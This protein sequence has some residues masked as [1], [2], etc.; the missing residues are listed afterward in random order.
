MAIHAYSERQ[1]A[2]QKETDLDDKVKTVSQD[3]GDGYQLAGNGY[4]LDQPGVFQNRAG[5]AAP[6]LGK[7][8]ER[9][10]AA[11]D[12]DR[13]VLRAIFINFR[14]DKSQDAHGDQRIQ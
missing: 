11:K 9:H 12:K 4:S 2:A 7:E 10:Q 3:A 6:S 13:E 5:A 8:I 14:K 1:R